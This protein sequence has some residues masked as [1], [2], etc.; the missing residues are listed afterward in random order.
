MA[1][2]RN[3]RDNGWCSAFT[4][5]ISNSVKAVANTFTFRPGEKRIVIVSTALCVGAAA[6]FATPSAAYA[7]WT[8]SSLPL[9]ALRGLYAGGSLALAAIGYKRINN[10]APLPEPQKKEEKG[11][12]TLVKLQGEV[13]VGKSFSYEKTK[14][15]LQKAFEDKDAKGVVLHMNSPG[16]SPVQASLIHNEVMRLK[17]EYKK[18]VVVVA[19]DVLASA[20]YFVA[21]SADKIYVNP[22]SYVGS[23]GVVTEGFGF[24]ELAKKLGVE[25]RVHTAGVNKRRLDPF[26]PEKPEDVKNLK[27]DL[28][29]IHKEF[30]DT[31]KTDRGAKLKN[32]KKN[33]LFSGDAWMGRRALNYG[34]VDG[35]GDLAD[36]LMNEFKVTK[37]VEFKSEQSMFGFFKDSMQK[38]SINLNVSLSDLPTMKL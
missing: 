33:Q 21:V 32:P 16:G 13:G 31:V 28:E 19:E 34:L 22:S 6:V 20:A 23:I 26:L 35:I 24:D 4:Q 29:E 37:T 30:I 7:L 2:S 9:Y 18:T 27:R 25:H 38:P 3:R 1:G 15:L 36:V 12:V 11:Y 5:G 10:P 8:N 14:P 17:K